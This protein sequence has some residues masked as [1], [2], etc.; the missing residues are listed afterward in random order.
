MPDFLSLSKHHPR[1]ST[2]IRL[3]GRSI[4]GRR[5]QEH[6][7]SMNNHPSFFAGASSFFKQALNVPLVA[8]A[9]AESEIPS[10][11]ACWCGGGTGS[12]NAPAA[13]RPPSAGSSVAGAAAAATMA[14]TAE[15]LPTEGS[16]EITIMD[17]CYHPRQ[18]LLSGKVKEALRGTG[19]LYAVDSS[20]VYP[21]NTSGGGVVGGQTGAGAGA[22]GATTIL[23]P[24]EFRRSQVIRSL[25]M[26]VQGRQRE[27]RGQADR[28]IWQ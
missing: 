15:M 16:V 8:I 1:F 4:R 19:A 11:L 10:A 27:R 13:A 26:R 14:A 28:V 12:S 24:E 9:C 17:E 21:V 18:L 22:G 3:R 23:S 25:R 7:G 6:F 20:C 2:P 5:T